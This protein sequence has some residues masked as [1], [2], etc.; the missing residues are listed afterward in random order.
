VSGL[1]FCLSA[2][3]HFIRLAAL[4]QVDTEN[5]YLYNANNKRVKKT[6]EAGTTHYDW[7]NDRT[8]DKT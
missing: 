3:H 6:T 5:S 7:E 8:K 2:L 1:V 4:T